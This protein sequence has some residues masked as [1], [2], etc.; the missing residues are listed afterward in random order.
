[1]SWIPTF[2]FLLSKLL[3]YAKIID[4]YVYIDK[5]LSP[6]LIVSLIYIAIILLVLQ[7]Y[8]PTKKYM[9]EV[10][11]VICESS[12]KLFNPYKDVKIISTTVKLSQELQQ[13][14]RD[15]DKF[16]NKAL[17]IK[18]ISSVITHHASVTENLTSLELL[19]NGKSYLKSTD[20]FVWSLMQGKEI[21]KFNKG[22]IE[23]KF[24]TLSTKGIMYIDR[25]RKVTALT[26][27]I[28]ELKHILFFDTKPW[29][30]LQLIFPNKTL[31]IRSVNTLELY[32]GFSLLVK[33]LKVEKDYDIWE[34]MQPPVQRRRSSGPFIV[35][36]TSTINNS[37][38]E[39]SSPSKAKRII[40]G[41]STPESSFSSPSKGSP[42][43]FN[44]SISP[45]KSPSKQS[46]SPSKSPSKHLSTSKPTLYKKKIDF[47]A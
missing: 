36:S 5:I 47:L 25:D 28:Q 6:S 37:I 24:L 11:Q 39:S 8:V 41:L 27:P 43:T 32:N 35:P 7:Y 14:K 12:K 18:R 10:N 13:L 31:T 4:K 34:K 42:A 15:F 2:T 1:M 40:S 29:P 23:S 45:S 33:R 22:E 17:V 44:Q 46:I 9:K 16:N 38:G 3:I 19:K 26:Y 30:Y 20:D 21:E